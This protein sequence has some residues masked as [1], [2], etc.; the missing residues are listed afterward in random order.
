MTTT[1]DV[2]IWR[3]RPYKG[4]R[5]T[6]Y[7]VRWVVASEEKRETFATEALADSFRSELVSAARKGEAFDVETGHPVSRKPKGAGLSW[8]DFAVQFVDAK[9]ARASAN[10]RKNIA[11]TLTATTVALFR[12]EPGEFEPVE[13][14]TALREYAFNR[15]R[16]DSAPPDVAA[17]LRWAQRNTLPM[18]AWADTAWVDAV[19]NALATKLNG[20]P[21]AASTVKR[22]RRVLN[23]ALDH[24]VRH[25]I[26]SANPL[27]KGRG[28]SPKTAATVDRRC[29]LNPEQVGRL[30]GWIHPRPRT[31]TRLHAY[32]ATLYY[33][34]PRPEEAVAMRVRDVTLPA[35]DAADQWGELVFHTATP[36][37]GKHWTDSGEIHDTRHLKGRAEGETRIVL[38]HPALARILREHIAAEELKPGDLL[39]PGEKGGRLSGSVFRRAWDKAR[40]AVLTDEEY[41]SPV[42]RR[43]YDL[44]HT[45]LTTWLNSGVPPAQVAAWA[46]NSVPVLLST[47]ALCISGQE[48]DLKRRIEAAMQVGGEVSA[49]GGAW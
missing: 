28:S 40:R 9:W 25:G 16:R 19:L 37:V 39:F 1:Y 22:H 12:R 11:K 8:Y 4:K 42:G 3:I 6:T 15:N 13:V 45:C 5:G 33:A 21:A 44:R 23:I 10:N 48:A 49:G 18:T 36:E 20:R 7:T 41:E 32:F 38:A 47:Y 43:V 24:A 34:G 30:L 29:L 46:G 26:L 31:G 14:R 17:I 27:P 35:E 2:R